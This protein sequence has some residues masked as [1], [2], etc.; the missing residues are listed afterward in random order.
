MLIIK[1]VHIFN[2]RNTNRFLLSESQVPIWFIHVTGQGFI[3]VNSIQL[4]IGV[5]TNLSFNITTASNFKGEF[6]SSF[7]ISELL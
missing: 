3:A 5:G 7:Y 4:P 1:Y 2:Q 6:S